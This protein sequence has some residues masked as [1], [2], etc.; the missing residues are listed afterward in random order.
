M[1]PEKF[2]LH[3]RGRGL[4][5]PAGVLFEKENKLLIILKL[6]TGVHFLQMSNVCSGID[7]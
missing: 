2:L 7:I 4:W 3:R 1:H 5:W 6:F